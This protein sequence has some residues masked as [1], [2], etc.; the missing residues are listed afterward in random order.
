MADMRPEHLGETLSAYLDGELDA[1]GTARVEQLL[2]DDRSV[3]DQLDVLRRTVD[4][5][6]ALPRHRAPGTLAEDLQ[7][8]LER[9]ELIGGF[10]EPTA[11]P[12]PRRTP[13][14]AILSTAAVFAFVVGGMWF[15]ALNKPDAG[16][17]GGSALR[18]IEADLTQNDRLADARTPED[19]GLA[20][21][22]PA[23]SREKKR[24]GNRATRNGSNGLLAS[25]TLEQKLAAGMGIVS[26]PA[27]AFDNEPVR[28]HVTS[29][30]TRGGRTITSRLLSRLAKM[31]VIDA[32]SAP[33]TRSADDARVA[34]LFYR[35]KAHQNFGEGGG[36]Q[37]LVRASL[38]QLNELL[39]EISRE[40]KAVSSV[41]LS[42][43]PLVVHGLPGVRGALAQ[44]G[45]KGEF[46]GD[47]LGA[48]ASVLG[49]ERSTPETEA[50]TGAN[51]LATPG[52]RTGSPA[53]AATPRPTESGEAPGL[54]TSRRSRRSAK[55]ITNTASVS[56][57]AASPSTDGDAESYI[58]LVIEIAHAHAPSA[59]S[60]RR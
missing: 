58:T 43:G 25:A 26:V 12:E 15:M 33:E 41:K 5:V 45:A 35:G 32:A 42:S 1:E 6:V 7:A 53:A 13:L 48:L 37:I 27:H 22:Q 9:S 57:P 21:K 56:S 36:T 52:S 55:R 34:S 39:R 31:G 29:T 38:R 47:P 18:S 23:L 17:I 28:L 19:R 14:V 4:L 49:V 40:A 51:D 24:L 54:K 10:A 11:S 2:R 60:A 44:L 30:D 59:P 3:R 20:R 8:H 46:A 50:D 16:P